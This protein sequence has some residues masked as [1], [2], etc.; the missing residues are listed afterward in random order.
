MP[1]STPV[2]TADMGWLLVKISASGPMPTSRYCDH[3]PLVIS[4]FFRC[5]ASGE[6][7]LRRE[8]SSPISAVIFLAQRCGRVV[9]AAGPLFD[10]PLQHGH[11]ESHACGLNGHGNRCGSSCRENKVVTVARW[12]NGLSARLVW[13]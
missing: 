12:Q 13:K 1:A 11:G 8:R 7:G 6:P 10:H 3:A 9:I 2:P 5:I 4:K